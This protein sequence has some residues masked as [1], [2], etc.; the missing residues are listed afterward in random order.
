MPGHDNFGLG[1]EDL[2][3]AKRPRMMLWTTPLVVQLYFAPSSPSM[4][5]LLLPAVNLADIRCIPICDLNPPIIL[6]LY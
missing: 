6:L 1:H 2:K 5:V 3:G 4:L